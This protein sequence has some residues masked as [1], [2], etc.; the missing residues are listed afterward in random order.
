MFEMK[1][2]IPLEKDLKITVMDYD[3]LSRDDLIGETIIDLENRLLSK[4]R[5]TCGLPQTFCR[6]F[7]CRYELDFLK[8]IS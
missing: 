8:M 7:E 1:A 2:T 6:K 5:A 3:M 4:Y